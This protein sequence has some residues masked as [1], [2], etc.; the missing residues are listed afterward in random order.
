[1]T[2]IDSPKYSETLKVMYIKYQ[3]ILVGPL[4]GI[5]VTIVNQQSQTRLQIGSA[6]TLA[7]TIKCNRVFRFSG[8]KKDIAKHFFCSFV[9]FKLIYEFQS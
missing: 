3:S 1:M 9:H 6:C 4:V 5:V 2:R 7:D 8:F